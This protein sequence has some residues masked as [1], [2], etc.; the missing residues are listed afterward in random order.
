MGD[1]QERK[2]QGEQHLRRLH[3]DEQTCIVRAIDHRARPQPEDEHRRRLG[4]ADRSDRDTGA[5]D[6]KH[7]D[8]LPDVLQPGARL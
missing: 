8:H 6:A 7:E 2:E 4:G 5:R 1:G 3:D